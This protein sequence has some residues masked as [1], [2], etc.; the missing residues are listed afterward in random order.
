VEAVLFV[1]RRKTEWK[2]DLNHMKLVTMVVSSNLLS[3]LKTLSQ[4]KTMPSLL[5]IYMIAKRR[6]E[7]LAIIFLV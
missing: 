5:P 6:Y 4:L 3:R 7:L 2:A 1:Y